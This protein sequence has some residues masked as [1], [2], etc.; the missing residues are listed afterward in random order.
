MDVILKPQLFRISWDNYT[1]NA[2][3]IVLECE[4]V[5]Y[6]LLTKRELK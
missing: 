1:I 5:Q 3:N 4:T 2:L 6:M